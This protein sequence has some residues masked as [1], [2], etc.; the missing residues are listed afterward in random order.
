MKMNIEAVFF[1]LVFIFAVCFQCHS[2]HQDTSRFLHKSFALCIDNTD[3][4]P[5]PL[6]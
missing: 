2:Y 4:N 6:W 5:I 3:Y 1:H